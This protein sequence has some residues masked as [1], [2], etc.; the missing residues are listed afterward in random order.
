MSRAKLKIAL[1]SLVIFLIPQ[2]AFAIVYL[3]IAGTDLPPTQEL[4]VKNLVLNWPIADAAA[5]SK[6]QSQGYLVFLQSSPA[7][8]SAAADSAEKLRAAGV[9]IALENIYG[10][11]DK[12]LLQRL[13]A[14]HPKLSF[15]FLN[16]GG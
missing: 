2:T 1:F 11:A 15:L 10:W 3:R 12:E 7:D 13:A 5:I 14:A 6:L 16:P 4:G 9:I 8:I